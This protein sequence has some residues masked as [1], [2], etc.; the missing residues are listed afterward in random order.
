MSNDFMKTIQDR[1]TFYAIGRKPILTDGEITSL[2]EKVVRCAPTA[3]NSQ[4]GRTVVLLGKE[5]EKL[6][7]E[8]ADILQKIVPDDQFPKTQAKLS[9]FRSGY[10]TILFFE[11]QK[12][13]A[14]LQQK[15]ALYKENFPVWSLE[16][17]GMLQFM[18]WTALED[19]GYGASLQH[20]NPLID[21][22]VTSN[23]NIP[24]DWKLLAQMPFGSREAEPDAKTFLP[25]AGRVSVF[26]ENSLPQ[27]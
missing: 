4:G 2:V 17:S 8:T 19:A 13:V 1:R 21:N 23:W 5:H 22:A 3:F 26:R 10:G 16:S 12:T 15:F 11:D 14:E 18:I 6:W 20:Y 9:S 7:D 25:I 27:I 24:A